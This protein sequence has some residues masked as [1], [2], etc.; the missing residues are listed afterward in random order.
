M[1]NFTTS[2]WCKIFKYCK[3]IIILIFTLVVIIL[4]AGD[5]S[6]KVVHNGSIFYDYTAFD[7]RVRLRIAGDKEMSDMPSMYASLADCINDQKLRFSWN[8]DY[9][10]FG[11]HYKNI[12]FT[13]SKM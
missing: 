8:I 11:I 4:L 1:P 5:F 9:L 10:N 7:R 2:N 12:S 6:K 3:I 13:I